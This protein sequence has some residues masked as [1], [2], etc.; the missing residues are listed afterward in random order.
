M[1]Y[2]SIYGYIKRNK[3][4][5]MIIISIIVIMLLF[6]FKNLSYKNKDKILNLA[7]KKYIKTNRIY[8]KIK[9]DSDIYNVIYNDIYYDSD[10]TNTNT[11][12]KDLNENKKKRFMPMVSNGEMKCKLY[13]EKIFSKPFQKIRPDMLKNTVTGKN[14]E[15]DLYNDELKLAIEYNGEQHYKFF[16]KIHKNYEH[17]QT[18]KYRDEMKK[19]LCQTNGITL[20][21]V[22]YTEK[23]NIENY[24]FQQLNIKGF[25]NKIIN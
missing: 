4:K 6:L 18:Q 11:I 14:L 1:S 3:F 23:D 9:K 25:S 16:P 24:L 21:E 2:F 12:S 5:Y 17:F 10:I 15:L 8:R 13:L 22:P 20:I 7:K 19:M